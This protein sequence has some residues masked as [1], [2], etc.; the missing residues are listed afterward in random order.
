RL[1]EV[2]SPAVSVPVGDDEVEVYKGPMERPIGFP[3]PPPVAGPSRLTLE[4]RI[5][6]WLNAPDEGSDEEEE[7]DSDNARLAHRLDAEERGVPVP[8][9]ADP[10]PV[11]SPPPPDGD[12]PPVYWSPRP[13][14]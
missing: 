4:E 10:V 6:G 8:F 2:E 5:G 13:T 14:E 12:F 7:D 3:D 11:Y 9:I 1:I